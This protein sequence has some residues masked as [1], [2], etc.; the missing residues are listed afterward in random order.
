M[1]V[2][3]GSIMSILRSAHPRTLNF[4]FSA[5]SSLI[6][7]PITRG[8]G[9]SGRGY[10]V[11]KGRLR[12]YR[13]ANSVSETDWRTEVRS[14]QGIDLWRH[15]RSRCG[16]GRGLRPRDRSVEPD[17]SIEHLVESRGLAAIRHSP[18]DRHLYQTRIPQPAPQHFALLALS[19]QRVLGNLA[20]RVEHPAWIDTGI[21]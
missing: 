7:P 2:S 4:S 19:Q 16:I 5:N 11:P 14:T 21:V 20:R 3:I 10:A 12:Y 9:G 18:C 6:R 15:A 13:L 17:E 8:R 1:L